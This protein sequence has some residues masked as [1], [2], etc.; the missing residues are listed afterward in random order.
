MEELKNRYRTT[1]IIVGAQIFVIVVLMAAAWLKVFK[2]ELTA[3]STTVTALWTAIIFIAVGSFLLRRTFYNWEKLKNTAL[4]KGISGLIKQLQSNAIILS[5]IAETIAIIG[6]VI[7]A[8]TGDRFQMLRAGIVALIV[9]LINFPR[10][11]VWKKI[12]A[13]VEKFETQR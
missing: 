5:A 2:F 6:F 8:L 9:C 7:T 13:N 11:G 4:L 1:M 10:L 3:E 12:I